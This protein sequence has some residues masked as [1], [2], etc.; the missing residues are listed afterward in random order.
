MNVPR[1]DSKV[2]DRPLS[3][4]R[5]GK[6]PRVHIIILKGEDSEPQSV[7]SIPKVE[8]DMSKTF[9]AAVRTLPNMLNGWL[10]GIVVIYGDEVVKYTPPVFRWLCGQGPDPAGKDPNWMG[11]AAEGSAL[12]AS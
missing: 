5:T 8:G 12:D 4:R 7:I 2:K 10:R 9:E 6:G 11:G 3:T 1:E